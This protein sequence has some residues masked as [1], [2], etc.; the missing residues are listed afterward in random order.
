M[1]TCDVTP[2]PPRHRMLSFF[3]LIWH[4]VLFN[5][6]LPIPKFVEPEAPCEGRFHQT[7]SFPEHRLPPVCFCN[8]R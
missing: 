3:L 8:T 1:T 6:F 7:P 2:Q 4:C 5:P